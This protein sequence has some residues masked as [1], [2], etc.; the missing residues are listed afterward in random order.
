[1]DNCPDDGCSDLLG[2]LSAAVVAM[3]EVLAHVFLGGRVG[4]AV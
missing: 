2:L 4:A 1:M 3:L